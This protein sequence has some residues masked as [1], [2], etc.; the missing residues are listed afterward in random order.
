MSEV[1]IP[2]DCIV[3]DAQA[4]VLDPNFGLLETPDASGI[5]TVLDPDGTDP[6]DQLEEVFQFVDEDPVHV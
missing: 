2:P 5:I 6:V 1:K 3:K 4:S